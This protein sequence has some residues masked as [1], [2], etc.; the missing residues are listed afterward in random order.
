MTEKNPW[1]KLSSKIVYENPWIQV[2]EDQIIQPDGKPGIYGI[3]NARLATGVLAMTESNEVYLVGQY[4]YPTE[5]YSWE[6]IEGGSERDESALE[7]AKRELE[8]EAGLIADEWSE[9]GK[10]F[11][12]SNCFSSERARVFIARNLHEVQSRPDGTEI[13]KVKKVPFSEALRMVDSG[14]IVDA[15]TII[16]L[17]R[18]QRELEL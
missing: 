1:K 14:E 6:I 2:Q 17:F 7:T 5:V 8:E 13:L 4:R 9:L 18:A 15:V 12:L 3:V 10:E 16:A 11:H